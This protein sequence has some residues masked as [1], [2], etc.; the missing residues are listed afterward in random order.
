[1]STGSS[2]VDFAVG[3]LWH[4]HDA[5][6]FPLLN[7]L[8]APVIGYA[9][10]HAWLRLR[11]KETFFRIVTPISWVILALYFGSMIL[12]GKWYYFSNESFCGIGLVDVFFMSI[13]FPAVAGVGYFMRKLLPRLS[14]WFESLGV[15][16]CSF[17][18]IHWVIY[19]L[20]YLIL[21]CTMGNNFVPMWAVPP[22]AVLVLIAADTLSHLYKNRQN[23]KKSDKSVDKL[24]NLT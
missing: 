10:G 3:Y 15:R 12:A 13:T 9:L 23:K 21:R 6:Y 4:S 19:A 17:Y 5:S 1:V 18:C 8:I 22:T 20:L 24:T 16:I 2:V 14:G 7:W 11:D